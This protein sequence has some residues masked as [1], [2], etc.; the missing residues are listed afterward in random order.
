MARY[1]LED[2]QT[3]IDFLDTHL[4]TTTEKNTPFTLQMRGTLSE[5]SASDLERYYVKH[6]SRFDDIADKKNVCL[7]FKPTW[8]RF[9]DYSKGYERHFLELK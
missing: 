8:A 2:Y 5:G 6:G 7:V 1:Q 3:L 9:T 4:A